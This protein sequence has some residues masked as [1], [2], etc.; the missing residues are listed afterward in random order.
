MARNLQTKLIRV[1]A[2]TFADWCAEVQELAGERWPEVSDQCAALICRVGRR[3][4]TRAGEWFLLILQQRQPKRPPA[5]A[6]MAYRQL[7]QILKDQ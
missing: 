1:Q 2:Q 6:T 3:R 4:D 5:A 7:W